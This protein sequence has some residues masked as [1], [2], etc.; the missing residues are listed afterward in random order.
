MPEPE[1]ER[2]YKSMSDPKLDEAYGAT[3]LLMRVLPVCPN[4]HTTLAILSADLS[5]ER[6]ARLYPAK[7]MEQLKAAKSGDGV[8]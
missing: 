7:R 8:A 2:P 3:Q 6:L 1:L 4:V 5:L